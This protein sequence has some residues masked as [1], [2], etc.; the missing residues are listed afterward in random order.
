MVM[1]EESSN[2]LEQFQQIHGDKGVW[3]IVS[4]LAFVLQRQDA[5]LGLDRSSMLANLSH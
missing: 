4:G 5:M 2:K 1:Q 3:F